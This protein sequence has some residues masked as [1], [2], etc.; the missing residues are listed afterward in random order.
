MKNY[1]KRKNKSDLVQLIKKIRTEADEFC[2]PK[3][4]RTLSQQQLNKASQDD[5]LEEAHIKLATMLPTLYKDDIIPEH[6]IKQ[7]ITLGGPQEQ[8]EFLM[9]RMEP[10]LLTG[11]S[12]DADTFIQALDSYDKDDENS[13]E[14]VKSFFCDIN[15]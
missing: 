9:E 10:S 15:Q 13:V 1:G 2:M 14:S 4:K 6:L 8:A 12:D 7:L 11:S 5:I 3:P